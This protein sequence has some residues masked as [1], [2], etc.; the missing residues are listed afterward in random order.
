MLTYV[1]SSILLAILLDE[2]RKA[3]ALRL[4][5]D[6]SIRVSSILLRMETL[7]VLWRTHEHNKTVLPPHW[8]S[9]KTDELYEF[10]QEV[11]IRIIDEDI[12][13]IMTL[14]KEIAKCRTLDAIHLSTALDFSRLVPRSGF[15][16]ITF[17]KEMA[18][19]AKRLK[20]NVNESPIGN[21]L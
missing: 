15:A 8:L 2:N 3:E 10:L 18:L 12:E 19:L 16:L 4:W 14:N 1:D 9:N 20:M 21:Y 6:T 5:T 7:T 17:D 11:N 13:K